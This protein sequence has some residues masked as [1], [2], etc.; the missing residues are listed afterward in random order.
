MRIYFVSIAA[1]KKK[2]ERLVEGDGEAIPE[3]FEAILK[4]KMTGKSEEA[5][6][7]LMKDI[8]SHPQLDRDFSD[9]EFNISDEDYDD[10][11]REDE[12]D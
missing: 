3:L 11:G 7:E 10:S 5:D 8:R 6:E 2:I 4:R 12:S 1:L 9:K